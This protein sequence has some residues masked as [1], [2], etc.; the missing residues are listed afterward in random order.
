[1]RIVGVCIGIFNDYGE[2]DSE[3]YDSFEGVSHQISFIGFWNM[4]FPSSID[5]SEWIDLNLDNVHQNKEFVMISIYKIL[6]QELQ[7]QQKINTLR[8]NLKL[9]LDFLTLYKT[10]TKFKSKRNWSNF[11]FITIFRIDFS[12]FEESSCEYLN[13]ADIEHILQ[14]SEPHFVVLES[15]VEAL[16]RRIW[17]D[18]QLWD[19][20]PI[21]D[22][23]EPYSVQRFR[24]KHNGIA[25][26]LSIN[27]DS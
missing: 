25:F 18:M 26:F 21:K 17:K 1:M 16:I 27:L 7:Y 19:E 3:L 6:K 24:M 5:I 15:H 23:G 4:I 22:L 9:K 8:W 14:K 10:L 12:M 11:L 13:R 2:A 20:F